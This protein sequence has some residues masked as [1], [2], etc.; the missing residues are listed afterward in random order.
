MNEAMEVEPRN[1]GDAWLVRH[2]F[3]HAAREVAALAGR[4][5]ADADEGGWAGA[6]AGVLSSVRSLGD[7][8]VDLARPCPVPGGASVAWPEGMKR[9]A[10]KGVS[11]L[12]G[13]PGAATLMVRSGES[14]IA[15]RAEHERE[16]RL[17]AAL[18]GRM[19]HRETVACDDALR[20]RFQRLFVD[21][22]R[23]PEH[24][25]LAALTAMHHGLLCLS[26]GPGTGKTTTVVRLLA[27]LL[28]RGPL[29]IALAAPTGKAAARLSQSI[30]RAREN[31]P[32]DH[33]ER[34]AI[35]AT[36][37]TLHRLLGRRPGEPDARRDPSRLL[38]LDVL[39]VDEASMID[40]DLMT[41]L[42]G[43]LPRSCRLIL[44]GDPQ[45]LPS[46]GPGRVLGDLVEA[47]GDRVSPGVAR[48]WSHC[49]DVDLPAPIGD[50]AAHIGCGVRLVKTW[51][52]ASGGAI[53]KLASALRAGDA[54]LFLDHLGAE[55]PSRWHPDGLDEQRLI[56]RLREVRDQAASAPGP[57]RALEAI[58]TFQLLCATRKGEVGV[59]S[60]RA[61]LDTRLGGAGDG[62]CG[63]PV[64]VTRNDPLTGLANGDVGVV[65]RERG[66][67]DVPLVW[68]AT[69]A[70]TPRAFAPEDLPEHET[71]WALTVH[72]SQG[73]E[74]EE[75]WFVMD[76]SGRRLASRALLYTAVTRAK[77]SLEV[78]ATEFLVSSCVAGEEGRAS[79]LLD[80]LRE[81]LEGQ[82]V[83]PGEEP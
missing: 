19:A 39:V 80:R 25:A 63:V 81:T 12:I 4:L 74:Y 46:V 16:M 66:S 28:G 44:V 83:G 6:L 67:D 51:R 73:S 43:A 5:V 50:D 57:E 29:E 33:L 64:I 15:L 35:P 13:A 58:G 56:D 34:S 53:G 48:A 23:P 7:T 24:Q 22:D 18:A 20:D 55:S 62:V 11:A 3:E 17:A 36:V 32:L 71:A 54:A 68:F 1:D 49:T 8:G 61:R 72:K 52:Y 2:G 9:L 65:W 69:E 21:E 70:G 42:L 41:S 40:L 59:D 60:V 82:V 10:R 27:L 26:G 14:W 31:L 47:T 79:G 45:Q 38:P 37:T 77:R 75:V 30:S 76:E 78:F